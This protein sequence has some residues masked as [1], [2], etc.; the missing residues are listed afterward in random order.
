MANYTGIIGILL[1][2]AGWAYETWVSV[3]A[4]KSPIPLS[5]VLL[6]G[7]GSALLALYAFSLNDWIF[8]VLNIVLVFMML[9]NIALI[10]KNKN[11]ERK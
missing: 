6:Y 2:L 9:I 5:L 11:K 10:L 1:I 3:K 7:I 4:G 8:M